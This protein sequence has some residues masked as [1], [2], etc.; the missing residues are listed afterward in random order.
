[1]SLLAKEDEDVDSAIESDTEPSFE[2]RKRRFS[3]QLMCVGDDYKTRSKTFLRQES[4]YV[5]ENRMQSE[6]SISTETQQ[7]E[8]YVSIL[9]FSTNSTAN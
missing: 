3:Q 5:E 6:I 7:V 9:L 1:M 8:V 4:L 2:T